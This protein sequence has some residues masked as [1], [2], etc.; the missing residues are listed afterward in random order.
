VIIWI[1]SKLILACVA[2]AVFGYWKCRS[3]SLQQPAPAAKNSASPQNAQARAP[4]ASVSSSEVTAAPTLA[5]P[6]VLEVK[7]VIA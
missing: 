7:N 4:P 1:G 2:L 3:K 6:G 5:V